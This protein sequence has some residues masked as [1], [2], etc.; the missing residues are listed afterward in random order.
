MQDAGWIMFVVGLFGLAAVTSGCSGLEIGG[1][2][3]VQRVDE[4]SSYQK[5]HREAIPWKCYFVKCA[6]GNEEVQGS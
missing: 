1:K 2:A 3:W 5:T 4:S 6:G